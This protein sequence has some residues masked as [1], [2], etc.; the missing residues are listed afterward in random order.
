MPD[1]RA[2]GRI[3]VLTLETPHGL[4]DVLLTPA[5]APRYRTLARHAEIVDLGGF[6]VRVASI[7]H[8]IAMKE[9]SGRPKDLAAVEELKAIRRVRRGDPPKDSFGRTG[10]EVLRQI[11][12]TPADD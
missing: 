3:Q 6:S 7:E 1:A 10:A 5:G 12:D 9:T 8:M 2:L 4:L 11:G